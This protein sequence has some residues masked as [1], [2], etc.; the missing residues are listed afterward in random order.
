[1]NNI[2]NTS[3]KNNLRSKLCP[4]KYHQTKIFIDGSMTILFENL[5]LEIIKEVKFSKNKSKKKDS[6]TLIIINEYILYKI[7]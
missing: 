5:R 7:F 3:V 2:L 4:G 1:M 6:K